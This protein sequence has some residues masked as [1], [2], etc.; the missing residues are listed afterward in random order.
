M[1]SFSKRMRIALSKKNMS[2]SEL[3]EKTGIKKSAMSQYY[4]GYIE[5]KQDKLYLIANALNVNEAW[6][7]G[8]DDI[9]MERQQTPVPSFK[10]EHIKLITL[11]EK[12]PEEKKKALFTLLETM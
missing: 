10:P 8:Y 1:E 9:E 6:L 11:Y 7:L 4:N 2:Q 3:C 12:L 5:P